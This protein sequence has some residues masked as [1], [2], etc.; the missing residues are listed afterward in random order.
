MNAV[1]ATLPSDAINECAHCTVARFLGAI[2]N[3]LDRLGF[4]SPSVYE[5]NSV[6]PRRRW[7]AGRLSKHRAHELISLRIY[8]E[9]KAPKLTGEC[10][11]TL[12]AGVYLHYRRGLKVRPEDWETKFED[13]MGIMQRPG[14]GDGAKPPKPIQILACDTPFQSILF[15]VPLAVF[16]KLGIR[17]SLPILKTRLTKE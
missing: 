4:P 12:S 13:G 2:V 9:I 1:N 14:G 11:S 15:L 16:L 7:G 3:F 8:L 10:E 5:R 6:P 17:C